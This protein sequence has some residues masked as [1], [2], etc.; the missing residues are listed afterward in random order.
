MI[1]YHIYIHSIHVGRY[2][3]DILVQV[4]PLRDQ[5]FFCRPAQS[6]NHIQS[7]RR[8]TLWPTLEWKATS[9]A[10]SFSP[11]SIAPATLGTS[12][13]DRLDR[14]GWV[15]RD[16]PAFEV[17]SFYG[18]ND[19][20]PLFFSI[21]I[22]LLGLTHLMVGWEMHFRDFSRSEQLPSLRSRCTASGIEHLFYQDLIPVEI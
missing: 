11:R 15:Q 7:C 17:W 20:Q 13:L 1:T 18:E 10:F 16:W 22:L 4:G 19:G 12:R 14:W 6:F 21:G 5:I 2:Y 8:R 9:C 3:I